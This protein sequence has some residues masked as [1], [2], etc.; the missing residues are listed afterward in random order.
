MTARR[1]AWLAGAV[2]I[3]V[4]AA[5]LAPSVTFWDAGEF[6]AAAH[7]LGIP[8][9]PG[10][11]LFIVAL[12][13]WAKLW[14]MLPFAAAT[15]SFS[16]VCTAAAG[17]LTALVLSRTTG[18]PIAAFVAALTAGAMSTVWMNATETE[19][20]AAS[21]F[22]S[23][24]TIASA[25]MAGRTGERRWIVLTAYLIALSVP[26]HL[27]SLVAAPVA[28]F[29]A[30]DRVDGRRDWL[31]ALTLLGV[32]VA[33][34]GIGR[35]S[36]LLV[37]CGLLVALG[38]PVARCQ[39]RSIDA[40]RTPIA[41]A[42][43]VALACTALAFLLVRS[44]HD[45]AI[46]QGNPRTLHELAYVVSRKQYAV[47]G[48]WPREAPI[49]LQ[50]ANWFEY[51]DWQFALVLGPTV[52]PTVARVIAT[53]VFA[54]LG[55]FG[56]LW[57]RQLDR[58]SWRAIAL[59]FVCGSLGVIVYLNLKAGRSFGWPFIPQDARHEARDRDYFFVLG[60]WAWGVWA[61]MGG[62]ALAR[63]FAF[64]AWVGLIA[65][66]LP[67]VLNWTVVD[68]RAEPEASLPRELAS[69]LLD[70]LPPRTVLFVAG[71]ND[72]YPLWY[73][74]QVE[75]RRRDVTIVTIPLLAAPWYVDEL[76][77]RAA[78]GTGDRLAPVAREAGRIAAEARAS[79]RLV[80]V[81]LTVAPEDRAQLSH[82]W[83]VIGLVALDDSSE[84]I[85]NVSR[86]DTSVVMSLDTVSL[87]STAARIESWLRGRSPRPQ[88]DPISDYFS[89][90]LACPSLTLS[91]PSPARSAS[92]DSLCN[93]R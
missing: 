88:P 85:R 4:Y 65:A 50:L 78:L 36:P 57:H 44:A 11:P 34:A 48:M 73:A 92:L 87:R 26:V 41:A 51:A 86:R 25:E 79:G 40:W 7:A 82:D 52:I 68:R 24:A 91:P 10:T 3:A 27:S 5:T 19:V 77:R 39:A 38:A 13:A 84:P 70:P 31:A 15:N 1:A 83:K 42:A 80:A 63:R 8:H 49:W 93:L 2:L 35:M 46:N 89:R 66:A 72:T 16:A 47:P 58:R 56:S 67:L 54:A 76:S 37:G 14:S 53:I 81:S 32:S 17:A 6:I 22:L 12:D 43:A 23:L 59:L 55:V 71:D 45:P 21:L 60:F 64:P 29:L 90:V 69:T 9:P 61:G 18:A 75:S 28:I 33:V 30:A 62:V 74:H 20:Y